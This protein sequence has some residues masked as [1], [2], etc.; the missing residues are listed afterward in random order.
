MLMSSFSKTICPGLRVGYMIVPDQ[1]MKPLA[2][3]AEDT[4]INASYINQA[5]A[6]EFIR[7]GWFDDNLARLK[8]LYFERLQKMLS[9]LDSS[10]SGLGEWTK[11]DGG[12]FISLNL[13]HPIPFERLLDTAR[14]A[15][16]ELSDGRGFFAEGGGEHFIRLPFCGLS[17]EEIEVGIPTLSGVIADCFGIEPVVN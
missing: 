6:Y 14:R 3:K 16:L 15:G 1:L 9:C 11:P 2:R 10:M 17:L 13:R 5:T 12:F 7:R 4:Y 8:V